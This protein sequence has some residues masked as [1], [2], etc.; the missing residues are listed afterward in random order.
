MRKSEKAA[1]PGILIMVL[2]FYR[3]GMT[4]ALAKT[5]RVLLKENATDVFTYLEKSDSIACL[6]T[7]INLSAPSSAAG[8]FSVSKTFKSDHGALSVIFKT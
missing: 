2:L 4:T 7:A 3:A 6:M 8:W 1:V 5:R